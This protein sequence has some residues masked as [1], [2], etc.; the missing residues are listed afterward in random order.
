MRFE[1]WALLMGLFVV[2][3]LLLA[4]GHRLR[5]RP[6]VWRRVFWGGVIGHSLAILVMLTTTLY[7]PVAWEGGPRSRD[8][9]V[10]GSLVL[11]AIAGG[12]IAAALPARKRRG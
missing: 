3:A 9:A 7:P 12:G 2:P 5:R 11:G 4:L 10:H 1:N 8:A 6:P